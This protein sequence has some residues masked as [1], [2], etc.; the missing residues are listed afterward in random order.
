MAGYPHSVA[1][2][3]L[4]LACLSRFIG[5][6]FDAWTRKW[7]ASLTVDGETFVRYQVLYKHDCGSLGGLS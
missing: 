5:V 4:A 6:A 1:R 3:C 7:T 2:A